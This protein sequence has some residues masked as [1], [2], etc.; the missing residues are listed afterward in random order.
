MILTKR[1]LMVLLAVSLAFTGVIGLMSHPGLTSVTRAQEEESGAVRAAREALEAAIEAEKDADPPSKELAVAVD[2]A[3]AAYNALIPTP[4]A[5]IAALAASGPTITPEAEPN[6]SPATANA[7]NLAAAPCAIVSGA[8]SPVGDNDYYSFTVGANERVWAYVDTGGVQNAGSTS[9]DSILTL[10]DTDGTTVL[11]QDDDDGTGTGCDATIETGRSS[12]IGGHLLAS[13]GTYYLRVKEENNND[14]MDPYKL[15]LVV[16]NA[17]PTSETE[18]NNNAAQSNPIVT[19]SQRIGLR[20]GNVPLIGGS[21]DWYS[22]VADA[23]DI[24][25]IDVDGNPD[26][27]ILL[28]TDTK[29]SIVNTNGTSTILTADSSGFLLTDA[30]GFCY[31]VPSAG[32]YYIKVERAAILG[33]S[34]Y[35]IMV[36]ACGQ[37]CSLTCPS[38]TTVGNDPNQCAAVVSY[39]A[40]A[41]SGSCFTVTC[42]PASG[43]SF[44]KGTTTVNC[45][46]DAGPACSFTVTVQ[47]TQNPAV[48]CPSNIATNTAPGQCSAV[49]SYA[50]PTP[51]DNCPGATV[52]CSPASG[53]TFP[54]GTTTVTCTATDG[55]GNT[56]SCSF[57]VQVNDT[58]APQ[59][60]CQALTVIGVTPAVGQPCA[61]VSYALP[62]AGDN[63]PGVSVACT[64]PSG[65]CFPLGTT[66]ITCI[67]TDASGNTKSSASCPP[68]SGITI[69]VYDVCIQDDSDSSRVLRFNSVSG[70][71]I[72]SCS[73]FTLT[74]KGVINKKGGDI[75]L[76]HNA[77]DRRVLAK[78]SSAVFKGSA[79]VGVYTSFLCDILDRDTRNNTCQ[80]ATQ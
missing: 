76:T 23:G 54:K 70:D 75:T 11:Q 39:M 32:T 14:K 7:L 24:L 31:A 5:G 30:E 6:G 71:Y 61:S 34:N 74:G 17:A 35:D 58:E 16:T 60:S 19:A 57:T 8:I 36:A 18:P 20:S 44:P 15:F 43:S 4:G 48:A 66:T 45:T 49:V 22:V 68:G 2:D 78:V 73:G 55:S 67:A 72:Y 10:F 50:T 28:S 59:I 46:S 40:P 25:F 27:S 21:A 1:K 9:R 53:S 26:R 56:G 79:S 63:C 69:S 42:S 47:D 52:S 12:V 41:T 64:P 65:S 29:V 37:P 77:T 33:T 13:A 62:A 3:Y 38:N 80:C 51:G